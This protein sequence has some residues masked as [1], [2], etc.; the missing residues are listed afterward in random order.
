[1]V[2]DAQPPLTVGKLG[3]DVTVIVDHYEEDWHRL[4][5]IRL[6]GS[7]RVLDQER[8]REHALT[9][10]AAKYPQYR[11]APPDGPVLAID[12]VEQRTWSAA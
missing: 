6:R 8:E 12:I 9:L 5:W 4:W 11:D 2:V 3:A 1:M 7:A 10:L